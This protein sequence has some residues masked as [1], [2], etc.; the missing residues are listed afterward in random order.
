M[1]IRPVTI[2]VVILLS[3]C[4][5]RNSSLFHRSSTS[6]SRTREGSADRLSSPPLSY[7][8]VVERTAPA[9]VTIRAA[10]RS[11]APRQFPFADDPFFRRFFGNRDRGFGNEPAPREHALGSG[12]IVAAD[13]HILT[14]HHVVDG[15][16]EIKIDLA[17]RRTLNAQL[18]GSDP[19]SDLAVL[20]VNSG[21]LPF[22]SLGDSDRVRVGDI[23]LALGNPLGVGQTV[24]AGII[25]AKSR[26]TGLSN[27]SYED[28]LQT[29]API[30]QGNSGGALV[31]TN[32]D[33]IG[34]NSQILSPTG[35][36]IGIG[37]AIPSNMA[38]NVMDQ[39]VDKHQVR[40]GQLGVGIQP[41][42][43]DVAASLGLKNVRGVLVNSVYAGSPAEKAGVRTGDIITVINGKSVE[44]PNSFRNLIASTPPGTTVTLTAVRDGKEQ[45][46]TVTLG[47]L[48]AE[49]ES[50]N[51]LSGDSQG[52]AG[53]QPWDFRG[54]GDAWA[55]RRTP[56]AERRPRRRRPRSRSSGSAAEVGVQ[57]GDVIAEVN[58]QPVRAVSDIANALKSAAGRPSI[59]LIHRGGQS[60][61]VTLQPR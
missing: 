5:C 35:T 15:A 52:A 40:R 34:I 19:P 30:N 46:V 18:V 36:N 55:G 53:G 47:E 17:D 24:T 6:E 60:L 57:P 45:Q 12:V 31:N 42:T 11:R 14:N 29:D 25:S 49:Q 8:D 33:L 51:R 58:R 2:A 43:S 59:L 13:G 9:V 21:N 56:V 7:S 61:F 1:I 48:N 44:D 50:A 54:A 23:C 37:F 16:E 26:A 32:G 28:F 4:A 27:G 41:V 22:L 38:K 20:K 3:Q 10:R 39:L